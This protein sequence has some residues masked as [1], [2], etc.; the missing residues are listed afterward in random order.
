MQ[1]TCIRYFLFFRTLKKSVFRYED[2]FEGKKKSGGKKDDHKKGKR[3]S[4]K[5]EFHDEPEELD[6]DDEPMDD[7]DVDIQVWQCALSKP[8]ET[9]HNHGCLG[10][11]SHVY[12]SFRKMGLFPLM[13]NNS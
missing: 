6:L 11:V 10:E 12:F 5:V 8:K 2:F 4:R 9:V 13:R 3:S 1:N 7:I